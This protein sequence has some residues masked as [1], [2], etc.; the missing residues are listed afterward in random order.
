MNNS[1]L[2]NFI[3]NVYTDYNSKNKQAYKVAVDPATIMLVGSIIIDIIKLIK[4]CKTEKEVIE[5]AKKPSVFENRTLYRV[6]RRRLG[7]RKYFN[8][9]HAIANSIRNK[10]ASLTEEEVFQLFEEVD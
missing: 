10:G 1:N 2:D 9:R 3:N 6:I 8:N 5:T 4:K 7:W